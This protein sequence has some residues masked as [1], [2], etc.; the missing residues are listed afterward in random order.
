MKKTTLLIAAITLLCAPAIQAREINKCVEDGRV[1]YTQRPCPGDQTVM[2]INAHPPAGSESVDAAERRASF[3]KSQEATAQ[4]IKRRNLN[5]R[6]SQ[7][8]SDRDGLLGKRDADIVALHK[9]LLDVYDFRHKALIESQITE[10][11][12]KYWR[13]KNRIE[14][15]LHDAQ[16]ELIRL[17]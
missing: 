3:M 10:V 7:L 1:T 13:D 14:R 17:Q 6:I 16:M 9:K 11:R 4:R 15:R 8:K 2:E 12:D 5:L